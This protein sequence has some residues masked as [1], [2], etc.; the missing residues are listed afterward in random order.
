M[1]PPRL[2]IGRERWLGLLTGLHARSEGSHE[3]GAFLLGKIDGDDR[4]VSTIIYY[5]ELD[6]D[7]YSTGICILHADSFERLWAY[8]R[9]SGQ[10][11]VADVHLHGNRGR[12]RQSCSDR[13]N[14]MI[15]KPGHLALIVPRLARWPIWR[16]HLGVYQYRGAHQWNDLSAWRA[17]AVVRTG[18]WR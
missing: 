15:A 3:S 2:H 12:A 18:T 8:C 6:P 7:A 4:T 13:T 5:D 9:E 11:V 14:P 16:H 1:T 10:S 17:R